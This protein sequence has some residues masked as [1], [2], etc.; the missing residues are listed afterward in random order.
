MS[1]GKTQEQVCTSNLSR[2]LLQSDQWRWQS[3]TEGDAS[4]PSLALSWLGDSGS[5]TARLKSLSRNQFSVEVDH[6]EWVDQLPLSTRA[7]FGPVSED[8]RVWSR[9]VKLVGQG[10]TWVCA[11]TLLPEHSLASPLSEILRLQNKPLGEYLFNHPD[12]LRSA[13]D[14]TPCGADTW[15]RRSVFFLFGK[16]IVVG[17]FFLPELL[18][19]TG[20]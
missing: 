9:Q 15:G 13:I 20:E 3:L 5:L 12:L 17:E 18:R 19:K 11:H 1:A 2:M 4:I 7:L 6:E 16:P 14:V 10:Q 8:H